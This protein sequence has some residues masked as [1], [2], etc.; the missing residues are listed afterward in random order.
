MAPDDL[1]RAKEARKGLYERDFYSWTKEQAALAREGR[2]GLL[3]LANIAEELATLGRSEA[4][5]LRSSYRLIL[6]HLLKRLLQPERLSRS[7]DV[8]IGQERDNIVLHLRENP[9][10]KSRRDEIFAVAFELARREA[11]RQMRKP[12]SSVP[13]DCPFSRQQVEDEAFLP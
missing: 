12:L 9:G 1:G 3:D 7:W 6:V 10:L 5:Q 8:T 11:A 13:V 2:H 4:A